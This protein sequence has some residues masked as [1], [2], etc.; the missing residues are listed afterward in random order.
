MK[1]FCYL[2]TI[3][4]IVLTIVGCE[5][6]YTTVADDITMDANGDG[7]I[8]IDTFKIKPGK[9]VDLQE[10]GYCAILI[11]TGFVKSDTVD[12][13]YISDVY[14]LESSNIYYTVLDPED[15][16]YINESLT[17]EKYEQSIENAFVSLGQGVDINIDE[18]QLTDIDGVPCYKIRS[19]YDNGST[20]IQQ[21]VYIIVA[22]ET[23]VITY[24]QSSDDELLFDFLV[25]DGDIKLVR[26][27][28]QS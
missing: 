4:L 16:G 26:E 10:I 5:K 14:P 3:C 2:L 12:G 17:A 19:H 6:K 11:P 8:T 24:S 21:L 22:S 20:Q 7:Y 1:K 13:M 9:K 27:I 23:H 15:D 28:S 18:F 25:D